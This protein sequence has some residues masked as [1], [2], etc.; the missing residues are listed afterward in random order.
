MIVKRHCD[1]LNNYF[2]SCGATIEP[3]LKGQHQWYV[4]DTSNYCVDNF[5]SLNDWYI[6]TLSYWIQEM[7]TDTLKNDG[8]WNGYTDMNKWEKKY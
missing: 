2:K 1:M 4:E 5:T 7:S 3:R 8:E 6:E